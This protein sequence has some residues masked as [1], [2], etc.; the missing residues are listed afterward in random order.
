MELG[1]VS[2]VR[3]EGGEVDI[4]SNLFVFV[5]HALSRFT[6]PT[7]DTQF[8]TYDEKHMGSTGKIH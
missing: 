3:K 1:H 8:L 5:T 6:P 7:Y 2:H 4:H